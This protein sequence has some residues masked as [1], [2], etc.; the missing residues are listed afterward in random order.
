MAAAALQGQSS[1]LKTYIAE[2][3]PRMEEE[4]Q[5]R[6]DR[7]RAAVAQVASTPLPVTQEQW[8]AWFRANEDDFYQKM[9][10]AGAARRSRNRRLRAAEDIPAPVARVGVALPSRP[11]PASQPQ[12]KQIVAKITGW[13]LLKFTDF[14]VAVVFVTRAH[15]S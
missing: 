8:I 5:R 11:K 15:L 10:T 6:R 7:D 12:W 4:L 2:N 14:S 9:N 13:H 1:E 3:R